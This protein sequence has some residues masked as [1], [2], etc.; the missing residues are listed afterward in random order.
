MA[1]SVLF[2]QSLLRTL[3]ARYYVERWHT[4][5]C[6][7]GGFRKHRHIQTH[8]HTHARTH[9]WTLAANICRTETRRLAHRH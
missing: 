6:D 9:R 3:L 2:S 7:G 1:H 8:T 4:A 5:H